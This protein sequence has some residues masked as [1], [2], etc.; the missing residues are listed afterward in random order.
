MV[1]ASVE[2]VV[3]SEVAEARAWG[4]EAYGAGGGAG[5]CGVGAGGGG[6]VEDA[7]VG[8]EVDGGGLGAGGG[9]GGGGCDGGEEEDGSEGEEDVAEVWAALRAECG[10]GASVRGGQMRARRP[11]HPEIR[12]RV[13]VVLYCNRV[14]GAAGGC[15]RDARVPRGGA[16]SSGVTREAEGRTPLW[17]CCHRGAG[18]PAR[19]RAKPRSGE[20]R[21]NAAAGRRPA[22]I[23]PP[24][25]AAA[26]QKARAPRDQALLTARLFTANKRVRSRVHLLTLLP[27]NCM[28]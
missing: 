22:T 17:G 14:G 25:A 20:A 7:G 24:P 15:G 6:D 19:S 18:L 16:V 1:S 9:L 5:A 26:G 4:M 12:R 28:A 11:A 10:A 21:K 3:V 8:V 2:V 27:R 23:L 13:G